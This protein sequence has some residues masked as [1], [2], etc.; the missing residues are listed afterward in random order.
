MNCWAFSSQSCHYFER[1]SCL[2][3]PVA[4]TKS[5]R[6][7]TLLLYVTNKFSLIDSKE[8]PYLV[9]LMLKEFHENVRSI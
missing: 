1:R 9:L 7:V 4:A 3:I 8:L 5:I 6:V 2:Y